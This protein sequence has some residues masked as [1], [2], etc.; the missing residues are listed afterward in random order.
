M[1]LSATRERST[2]NVRAGVLAEGAVEDDVR[3]RRRSQ[4]KRSVHGADFH[5]IRPDGG[6][7]T[8]EIG[9][10][11]QHSWFDESWIRRAVWLQY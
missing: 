5:S 8:L 11:Q 6:D 3:H 4:A 10:D 9:R 2:V 7:E 1:A